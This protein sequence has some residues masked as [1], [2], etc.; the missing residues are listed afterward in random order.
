MALTVINGALNGA[1]LL[2][3]GARLEREEE[4]L[5][6]QMERWQHQGMHWSEDELPCFCAGQP[7]RAL[8]GRLMMLYSFAWSCCL[9]ALRKVALMQLFTLSLCLGRVWH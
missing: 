6:R 4:A 2:C 8:S 7:Q 3:R 5:I 1:L 9:T